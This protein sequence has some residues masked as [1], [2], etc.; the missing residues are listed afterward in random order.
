MSRP[1]RAPVEGLIASRSFSGGS[2][3]PSLMRPSRAA[4]V[5]AGGP[6]HPPAAEFA[7]QLS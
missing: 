1:I 5:L 4:L 3:A 2:A 6:A 7:R